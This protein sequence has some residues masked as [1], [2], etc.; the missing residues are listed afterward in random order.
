MDTFLKL[1]RVNYDMHTN[2]VLKENYNFGCPTVSYKNYK[3]LHIQSPQFISGVPRF[4]LSIEESLRFTTF[5]MGIK[6]Y[7]SFFV[8]E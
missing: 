7:I 4:L 5:H 1:D 8:E 6:V 3:N 2:R